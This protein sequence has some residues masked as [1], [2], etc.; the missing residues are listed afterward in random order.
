L[1][2]KSISVT[3]CECVSVALVNQHAGWMRHIIL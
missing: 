2:G 3:Y 1:S